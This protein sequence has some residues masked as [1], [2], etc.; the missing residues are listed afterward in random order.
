MKGIKLGK[1]RAMKRDWTKFQP[2]VVVACS[3][4]TNSSNIG[5]SCCGGSCIGGNCKAVSKTSNV[6]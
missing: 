2:K 4:K 5:R 6:F 1:E 3:K